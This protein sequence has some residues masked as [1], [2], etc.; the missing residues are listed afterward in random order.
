MA[1]FCAVA[2]SSC[3]SAVED[4]EMEVTTEDYYY[5]LSNT[6]DGVSSDEILQ[7][8]DIS[9]DYKDANGDVQTA[10]VTSLPWMGKIEGVTPPFTLLMS[11]TLTKKE[12]FTPENDTCTF[13]FGHEFYS[14]TSLAFGYP[15]YS[16]VSEDEVA[17]D[18]LDDYI[19]LLNDI[20]ESCTYSISE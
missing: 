9:V 17:V 14:E 7:F 19:E 1:L 5:A 18:K 6:L 15:L 10:S 8:A 3:D 20:Y 2:L 11:I 12:D 13:I 16:M 4:P